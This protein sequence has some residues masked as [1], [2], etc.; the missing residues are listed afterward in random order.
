M[1]HV[2]LLSSLMNVVWLGHQRE[3]AGVLPQDWS[4]FTVLS[5]DLRL[6]CCERA[7]SLIQV[8]RD[9][10]LGRMPCVEGRQC[11]LEIL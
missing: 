2:S 8:E 5:C 7:S 10:H 4:V 1:Q 3:D 9:L 6:L 11:G